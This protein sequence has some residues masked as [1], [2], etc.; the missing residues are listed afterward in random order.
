MVRRYGR[1]RSRSARKSF[2]KRSSSRAFKRRRASRPSMAISHSSVVPDRFFVKL[3]YSEQFGM[4]YTPA[5]AASYQFRV[6]S[7]FDPNY[8]GTG[9]QPLGHDQWQNIYNRY[10]V[11]GC[12]Y[13]IYFTNISTTEQAE[14]AVQLRPNLTTASD[15]D[16]IRESAYTVYKNILGV[17]G[18][19]QATRCAKGY[20][21]VCK[22]RGMSKARIKAEDSF[23]ANFGS[24]PAN[25]PSINLHMQNQNVG[26]GC[27]IRAR[28]DLTFLCELFDRKSLDQS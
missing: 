17:E 23:Q 15:Y 27:T 28:V 3:K 4:T 26:T 12:K 5:T 16:T 19:G 14:V 6:N 2:R 22:L 13:R 11:Y 25:T 8:T 20:A 10:R 1:K 7:I 21:G 18:S 9:H 24:N